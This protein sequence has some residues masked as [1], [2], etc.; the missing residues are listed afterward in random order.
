M[1]SD[2][3]EVAFTPESKANIDSTIILYANNMLRTIAV[4]YKDFESWPPTETDAEG[5]VPYQDLAKDLTLLAVTAIEDPL[6]PGVTE[7]VATC[8]KVCFLSLFSTLNDID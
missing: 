7:A 6:R 4:C 5:N 2:V 1:A 8:N 3:E